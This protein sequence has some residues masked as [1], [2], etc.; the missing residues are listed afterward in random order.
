M[1]WAFVHRLACVG[2]A[3]ALLLLTLVLVNTDVL[4]D[5]RPAP[6]W[7]APPVAVAPVDRV[8][9][10]V[11]DGLRDDMAADA[12][13]MP[14]LDALARRGRRETL[15]VD[16]LIPST[17]AGIVALSTGR[18]V[19]PASFLQ[20]FRAR[21]AADGGVFA[22][23]SRGG[24]QSFVAGPPAWTDLYGRWIA[25][26]HASPTVDIGD[27]EALHSTTVALT[28]DVFRLMVVHFTRTDAAAHEFGGDSPQ[29]RAAATWCDA[30]VGRIAEL[31]DDRDVLIV[32]S[33]HGVTAQGGHAGREPAVVRTP[34]VVAG[35][36][37]S[38][39][40]LQLSRQ[41]D[42]AT[43]ICQ[44]LNVSPPLAASETFQLP[45]ALAIAAVLVATASGVWIWSSIA[46]GASGR[47]QAFFLNLSFWACLVLIVVGWRGVTLAVAMGSLVANAAWIGGRLSRGV[48]VCAVAGGIAAALQI[49][50]EAQFAS[51][52]AARS[53]IRHVGLLTALAFM[54]SIGF[55]GVLGRWLRG[56]S[57][58]LGAG[59]AIGSFLIPLLYFTGQTL[60]LS[61][62]IIAPA[63]RLITLPGGL[64][65]AILAV[66]AIQAI[67]AVGMTIV[68][69]IARRPLEPE[70]SSFPATIGA[71][72]FISGGAI[73]AAV[74][75]RLSSDALTLASLATAAV[76]RDASNVL[77]LLGTG[78][79]AGQVGGRCTSRN[80]RV[81]LPQ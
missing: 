59:A 45:R 12:A 43:A 7:E 29:Y 48:V 44:L 30:A 32:T 15:L 33:D 52:I 26:R 19:A 76:V 34:I 14:H 61:T 49:A 77:F 18:V 6:R 9:L 3:A 50:V 69:S 1:K 25:G 57:A 70:D 78:L 38:V 47:P 13:R 21:P 22:A 39:S 65:W 80:C 81:S 31:M 51:A 74:A 24:G 4:L 42:V 75:L 16:S 67:P 23:I 8:I 54:L 41:G 73:A 20:D 10:C 27:D 46:G 72:A 79:V 71:I 37:E 68:F 56:R 62:L 5:D 2:N 64:L 35:K 55:G 63:Y 28:S 53:S 66:M 11:I 17:T 60:S 36:L 58:T 40:H